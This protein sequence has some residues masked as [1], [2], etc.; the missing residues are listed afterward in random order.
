MATVAPAIEGDRRAPLVPIA[1]GEPNSSTL[2][3]KILQSVPVRFLRSSRNIGAD[4]KRM[5]AALDNEHGSRLRRHVRM[6]PLLEVGA[7]LEH[8]GLVAGD[9]K[10]TV[11][12]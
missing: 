8:A 11:G 1:F 5:E 7:G 12:P 2:S 3:K 9:I 10:D 4:E 6:Q